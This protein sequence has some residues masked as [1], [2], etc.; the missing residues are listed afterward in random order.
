MARAIPAL[1]LI[2]SLGTAVADNVAVPP[3]RA[4]VTDLTGTLS[5]S[6][7]QSLGTILA[8][9]EQKKGSQIA[10]LLLPS[11]KPE[12]IEQYSMR[13]AEAWKI[14]RK[15]TDDGLILVIAKD[16]HRLRI[17]VGRGLEGVEDRLQAAGGG[18]EVMHGF[19][20]RMARHLAQ[21]AAEAAEELLIALPVDGHGSR[22]VRPQF[23]RLSTASTTVRRT[24]TRA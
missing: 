22:A 1:A 3:L 20:L 13:V 5:A 16:D 23:R 14:G 6:Q 7:I 8:E 24:F 21:Q 10:V 15:N 12:A 18:A 11:T 4:R 19:G 9:F 17:E 2:L